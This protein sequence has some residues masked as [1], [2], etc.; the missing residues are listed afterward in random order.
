MSSKANSRRSPESVNGRSAE[1]PSII[2]HIDH[3]FSSSSRK[4]NNAIG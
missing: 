3:L 1:K 2:L 4:E